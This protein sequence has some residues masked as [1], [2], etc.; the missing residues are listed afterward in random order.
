M[1]KQLT[2]GKAGRLSE[3]TLAQSD[4]SVL[5]YSFK[6]KLDD[7]IKRTFRGAISKSFTDPTSIEHCITD[8]A[9]NQ[10][11]LISSRNVQL[12]RSLNFIF[13]DMKI[14]ESFEF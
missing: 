12:F 6:M 9:V 3:L 2:C 8:V 11:N 10:V 7:T 1:K 4:F 5:S 14:C 13:V